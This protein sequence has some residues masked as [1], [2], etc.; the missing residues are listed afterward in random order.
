ME[1]RYVSAEGDD[2]KPEHLTQAIELYERCRTL[3][4]ELATRVSDRYRWVRGQALCVGSIG[5]LRWHAGEYPEA[6]K[7]FREAIAICEKI[8]GASRM[9][10]TVCEVIAYYY[11]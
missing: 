3:T 7:M 2:R 9:S 5:K 10:H 8:P 1:R 4:V 6:E 11:Y